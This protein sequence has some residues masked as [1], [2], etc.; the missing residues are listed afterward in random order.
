MSRRTDTYMFLH[1]GLWQLV[2]ER[3]K[4]APV[5]ALRRMG[6]HAVP[7]STISSY[8][9]V[10]QTVSDRSYVELRPTSHYAPNWTPTEQ[11][12]CKECGNDSKIATL[13]G[14]SCTVCGSSMA[15][16]HMKSCEPISTYGTGGGRRATAYVYKRLNHF[17]DHLRRVQGKQSASIRSDVINAVRHELAKENVHDGDARIT[18]AKVRYVLKKLKLQKHYVHVFHIASRLSGKVAPTMSPA[19][20]EKLLEMFQAIQDPFEKHCPPDRTN[21]LSYT[22]VL[23]KFCEILGWDELAGYF[24]LLKSRNKVYMQDRIWFLICQ[25]LNY[26]FIKSIA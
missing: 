3:Y 20:E 22:Y 17:V 15:Y 10:R 11:M 23:R 2:V 7:V 12:I 14:Y 8:F 6:L 13:D 26:P 5:V 1:P 21:M 9:E 25:E 18:T 4:A 19:Q 24:P 16:L